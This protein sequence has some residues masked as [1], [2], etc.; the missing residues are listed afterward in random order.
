MDGFPYE[1]GPTLD[2][3]EIIQRRLAMGESSGAILGDLGI[4][5]CRNCTAHNTTPDVECTECGTHKGELGIPQDIPPQ[6]P[7]QTGIYY[8]DRMLLHEVCL[9]QS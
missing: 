1:L 2:V 9:Y 6:I 5:H 3:E 4:W 8:D 7:T